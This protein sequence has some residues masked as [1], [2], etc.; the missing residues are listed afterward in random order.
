MAVTLQVLRDSATKTILMYRLDTIVPGGGQE[1]VAEVL[2]DSDAAIFTQKYKYDLA[3]N[4]II[5]AL[6]Y[7]F[8]ELTDDAVDFNPV[9]GM[10]RLGKG[11]A[12]FLTLTMAKKDI[13]GNY[14]V[15]AGDSDRIY[16]GASG[17]DGAVEYVDL[18]NGV[19]SGKFYSSVTRNVATFTLSAEGIAAATFSVE[20][21]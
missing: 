17:G 6:S 4:L 13:E 15:A 1:V 14:H 8:L 18:V 9:N 16:I 2:S 19:V 11:G 20:S 3:G 12:N 10:P 5:N 21:F 7:Y